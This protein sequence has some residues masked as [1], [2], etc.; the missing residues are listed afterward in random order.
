MSKRKKTI[1]ELL[2]ETLLSEE[3]QLYT[4]P[5][6]WIWTNLGSCLENIQYG[7]TETASSEEIGPKFLRIT[8]IQNDK[9]DWNSVPYCKI[10]EKDLEK[11]LL[12][13][14]DIVVART[15]AT[16]EKLFN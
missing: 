11:Y 4:V 3:G 6:N 8:D 1:E 7:Y 9:V 2:G 13:D 5:E 16:T 14:D 12:K 15:G 10:N